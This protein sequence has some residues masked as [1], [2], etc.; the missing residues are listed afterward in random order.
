MRVGEEEMNYVRRSG[1]NGH[2]GRKSGVKLRLI[3]LI[4]L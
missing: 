4:I 3:Y 1:T 2:D